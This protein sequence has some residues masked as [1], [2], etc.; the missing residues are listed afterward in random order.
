MENTRLQTELVAL[1]GK[2]VSDIAEIRAELQLKNFELTALGTTFEDRMSQVRQ[3]ELELKTVKGECEAHKNAFVKLE[4]ESDARLSELSA[5]LGVAKNRLKAYETLEEEIDSA[6][7]RVAQAGAVSGNKIDNDNIDNED[8]G[9]LT[10][11]WRLRAFF[12][13][14]QTMPSQP[15]RRARQAVLLAQKVLEMEAQRDEARK[16]I[17]TLRTELKMRVNGSTLPM[18]RCTV[19]RNPAFI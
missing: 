2:S 17:A 4:A 7:L 13:T 14:L 6:V 1:Q 16:D 5:Q 8:V 9:K 19:V 12:A 11:I 10:G 18:R 3:A 15:E